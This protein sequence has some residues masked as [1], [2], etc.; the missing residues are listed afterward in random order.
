MDCFKL[1]TVLLFIKGI[2]SDCPKYVIPRKNPVR[3]YIDYH[4]QNLS[5][6]P[7]SLDMVQLMADSWAAILSGIPDKKLIFEATMSEPFVFTINDKSGFTV[8]RPLYSLLKESAK[9]INY[10]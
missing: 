5:G 7:K 3:G 9:F 6:F 1:L 2:N 4:Y 8:W 10:R